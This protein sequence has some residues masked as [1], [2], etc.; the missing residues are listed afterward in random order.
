MTPQEVEKM[1][2]TSR[3]WIEFGKMWNNFETNDYYIVLESF[4]DNL[5]I[6]SVTDE[7][8][9]ITKVEGVT[10]Y[11]AIKDLY[12]KEF[13]KNSDYQEFEFDFLP[14]DL[15][16]M[17]RIADEEGVTVDEVFARILKQALDKLEPPTKQEIAKCCFTCE[18]ICIPEDPL[19][20]SWCTK[21]N[22]LTVFHHVCDDYSK[23]N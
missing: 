11:A 9:V 14:K 22:E 13:L 10:P 16:E 6:I 21:R 1:S 4:N 19:D 7:N 3:K 20:A 23:H 12:F 18:H 8:G 5:Y 2:M 15:Q 17:E